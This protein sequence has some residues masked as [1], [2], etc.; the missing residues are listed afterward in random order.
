MNETNLAYTLKTRP[1]GL[2]GAEHFERGESPLPA[3]AAGEVLIR[4]RFLSIDPAMRGWLNEGK[5][6]VPPVGIGE[7]MR[8]LGAGEV[9]ES[10]NEK[11]KIGDA[12]TGML[13]IQTYAAGSPKALNLF[14][15]D[16]SVL[17]LERYLGALGMPGMTAYFGI[18]HVLGEPSPGETVVVS[19]AAGAVGSMVGQIARIKGARVVGIAGGAE[20]CREVVEEYGFDACIDYKQ[21]DV[22]GGLKKHCPKGIDIYFDNVGGEILEAALARLALHGRIIICGAISQYNNAD[23]QP[24]G[25]R[26]YL[27]LLVNRGTMKGMVVM[28]YAKDYPAAGM[29]IAQWI[30]QGQL[31]CKEHIVQ[32]LDQFPAALGMLFKGANHGKLVLQLN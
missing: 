32:G 13:G 8:A 28:D 20:K 4:N 6:Y 26:N 29:Q 23:N 21:E 10:R 25:P 24:R 1:Q 16:A 11:F 18:L 31:K 27:S 14:K 5:S 7:V 19:G 9:V 12:V 17:P 30:M 2:V 22:L 15:V 3:L